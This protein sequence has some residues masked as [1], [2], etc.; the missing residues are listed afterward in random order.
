MDHRPARTGSVRDTP[1]PLPAR[2]A[3]SAVPPR[4]TVARR[5]KQRAVTKGAL[6]RV[7]VLNEARKPLTIDELEI[8]SE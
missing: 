7:A 4:Y 6:M 5:A 1:E 2:L 8:G 3:L